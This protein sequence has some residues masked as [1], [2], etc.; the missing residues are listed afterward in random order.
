M[1]QNENIE[2]EIFRLL[3]SADDPTE[4]SQLLILYKIAQMLS[5][6]SQTTADHA[7]LSDRFNRHEKKVQSIWDRVKGGLTVLSVVSGILIA[8]LSFAFNT[9]LEDRRQEIIMLSDRVK[10]LE[11]PLMRIQ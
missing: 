11:T 6:A 4:R 8:S 5:A 7:E 2:D 10:K 1:T 9:M 3:Q